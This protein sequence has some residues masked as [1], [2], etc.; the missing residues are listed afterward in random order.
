ML[1][2]MADSLPAHLFQ[3]VCGGQDGV[4]QGGGGV[5]MFV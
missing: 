4:E 1:R 2:R 3:T 5:F